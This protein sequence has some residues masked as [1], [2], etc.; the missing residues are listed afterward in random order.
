MNRLLIAMTS[1]AFLCTLG[2]TGCGES[3]STVIQPQD[4]QLTDQEQQ[5]R[6]REREMLREQTQE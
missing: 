4:Y 6:E 1:L 3:G 2:L 5:N